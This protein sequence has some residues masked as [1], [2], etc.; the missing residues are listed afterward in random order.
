MV[1]TKFSDLSNDMNIVRAR[2]LSLAF[3]ESLYPTTAGDHA[4]SGVHERDY[5]LREV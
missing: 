1:E 5:F 3:V 4:V 2:A